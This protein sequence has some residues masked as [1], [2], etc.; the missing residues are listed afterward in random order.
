M[1]NMSP[2]SP[3]S[4]PNGACGAG[5]KPKPSL[6]DRSKNGPRRP[7]LNTVLQGVGTFLTTS[8]GFAMTTYAVADAG[9]S[10]S[11][12]MD[13]IEQ[14]QMALSNAPAFVSDKDKAA[15]L[16][17]LVAFTTA[18]YRNEPVSSEAQ[19][20]LADYMDRMPDGRLK[21]SLSSILDG[22]KGI[23]N[24]SLNKSSTNAWG[25]VGGSIAGAAGGAIAAYLK[26]RYI[27]D[28]SVATYQ[29]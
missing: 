18:L 4:T 2:D 3:V 24:E 17:V 8:V 6:P 11:E 10:K 29:G 28:N 13:R 27:R 23:Y 20:Q 14:A 7:K 9:A 25:W 1:Y 5:E 21:G 15:I 16:L 19:G 12:L 26:Q 22:A